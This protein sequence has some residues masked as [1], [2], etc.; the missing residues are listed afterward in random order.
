[1]DVE[2]SKADPLAWHFHHAQEARGAALRRPCATAVLAGRAILRGPPQ[3]T[4]ARTAKQGRPPKPKPIRFVLQCK[5]RATTPP[6]HGK[7]S[8]WQ[9]KQIADVRRRSGVEAA[10]ERRRT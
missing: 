3:Q 8:L 4:A 7:F 6:L 1:M 9:R 10:S 2:K 5:P